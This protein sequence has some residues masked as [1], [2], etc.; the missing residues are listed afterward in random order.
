MHEM[1]ARPSMKQE[2]GAF[3]KYIAYGLSPTSGYNFLDDVI[4]SLI[5]KVAGLFQKTG[6]LRRSGKW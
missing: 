3:P 6:Q 4:T 5:N 1:S 2:A